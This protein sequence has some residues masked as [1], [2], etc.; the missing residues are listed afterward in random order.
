M[1]AVKS[2]KETVTIEDVLE[3]S[4]QYIQNPDS[5]ALINKAY[6]YIMEKHEGQKRRSGEPYT[7]HLIWV[8]YILATL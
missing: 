6:A 4:G 2:A 3:Y 1:I 5:I 8:A 7:I